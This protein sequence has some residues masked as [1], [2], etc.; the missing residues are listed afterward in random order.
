MVYVGDTDRTLQN[1]VIEHKYAVSRHNVKNAIAVHARN[2][3]H[4]IDWE[5][6]TVH[7]GTGPYT[8]ERRVIEA[9]LL[10]CMVALA[11]TPG[12]GE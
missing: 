6:S 9:V 10:G 8:W 1:R 12:K 3:E 5:P 11:H 7:G 4:R 2:C